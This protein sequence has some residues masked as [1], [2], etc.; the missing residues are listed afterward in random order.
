MRIAIS[1]NIS[2]RV[3]INRGTNRGRG[4]MGAFILTVFLAVLLPFLF[5]ITVFCAF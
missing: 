5:M 1:M 3:I 2:P 4:S